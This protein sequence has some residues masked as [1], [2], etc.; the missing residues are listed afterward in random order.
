VKTIDDA[1]LE[2]RTRARESIARY[3]WSPFLHD[4]KLA[5]R[6]HRVSA[7]TLFVWGARDAV[8]APAYGR[9][10]AS[11]VKGAEFVEI[12]G[13]GHFPQAEQP[14]KTLE[15]ILSFAGAHRAAAY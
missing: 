4:P 3:A 15:A 6:L 12:E 14:A 2:R 1:E 5:G 7:P 10:Y 11:R 9:A 8:V 13:A